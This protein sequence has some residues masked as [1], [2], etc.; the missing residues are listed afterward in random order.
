MI[1]AELELREIERQILCT[2][3]MERTHYATLKQRPEAFDIGVNSLLQPCGPAQ[4]PIMRRLFVSAS[5][6]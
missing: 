2:Q 1:V 3:A 4:F 5:L 6:H